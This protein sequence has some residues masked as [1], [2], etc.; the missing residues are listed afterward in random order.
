ME[1]S[2]SCVTTLLFMLLRITHKCRLV[3]FL[4]LLRHCSR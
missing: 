4:L 1:C 3:C 2:S